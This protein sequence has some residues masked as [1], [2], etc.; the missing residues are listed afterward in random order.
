MSRR[1]ALA[2]VAA[3]GVAVPSGLVWIGSQQVLFPF[4]YH[5]GLPPV[6][7][8]DAAWE[9]W[10]GIARDPQRD[11]GLAYEDVEFPAEDGTILRGWW[12][13]AEPSARRAVVTV[14]GGASDRRD[15]LRHVPFLHDAGWDVLLFDC[16]EHG[17]SDNLG[18]G[19][20][21]GF[22]ESRDVSSAV[23]W[24]RGR[25]AD[26]VAVL[27]TSQGGSSA[28]IARAR[29]AAIDAVIAENPVASLLELLRGTIHAQ[30]IWVPEILI[31]LMRDVA[32][33][34]FGAF[35]PWEA[36]DVIDGVAPRP[37]LLMHGTADQVVPIR[38]SELLFERARE[39]KELWRADGAHHMRL[40]NR[41]PDEYRK[42]VLGF[43]RRHLGTPGGASGDR[44]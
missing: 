11:L 36:I 40:F 34:R 17:R 43:L 3:I 25:G 4:W 13:P 23:A 15:F 31:D 42:R 33:W 12:V 29:D 28:I 18:R 14:H 10:Q 2:V 38:H 44:G 35:G 27:G 16:R 32:V 22:R 19:I 9:T 24:S 37:L 5:P 26:L 30:R 8:G 41:H 1:L 6:A 7:E 39:P 20:S 21:V